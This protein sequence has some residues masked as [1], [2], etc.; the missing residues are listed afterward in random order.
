[1]NNSVNENEQKGPLVGC[2]KEM[3]GCGMESDFRE[4]LR[5]TE[6]CVR[7]D[8]DKNHDVADPL[9][10]VFLLFAGF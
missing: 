4:G 7:N 9:I 2:S 3:I 8:T 6:K 1:L 5:I 10:F